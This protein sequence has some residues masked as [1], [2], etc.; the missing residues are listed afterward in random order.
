MSNEINNN[1]EAV[2]IIGMAARL[3]GARN[4]AEYWDNLKKGV[5]SITFWTD[6]ELLAAGLDPEKIAN[7]NYV[8]AKGNIPEPFHFDAGFFGFNPREA[9]VLDPQHRVF[10]EC[11]WHAFEDAGY[12]PSR[13]EQRVGV[14]AG[15]GTTQYLFQL[16]DNPEV[17]KFASALSIVT[18]N[19]KDYISTRVSYKLNLTGPSV[20]VQSACSSS[21][22]AVSMGAQSILNYQCD[23][24]IAG[25]VSMRIPEVAG[26]WYQEGS[27]VSPD[28]HCRTFDRNSK[29]T[30]FSAGCAV[31]L[32]KRL[33]DAIRD[34]DHIYAV[35]KGS[36]V[37]NDG[38]LKIGYTAPSVDGQMEVSAEA[39]AMS[40]IHPETIH[41]FEAHGTATELGDPIEVNA[42]T[43]V[44]R[45][46]TDKQQYCAIASVK[47]NIGHTDIAAGTAGLIKTALTLEH[48]L[49][50][51]N[52]HYEAPNP[53]IDFDNSPFFVNTEL[54]SYPKADHPRR[55]GVNSFG[56]GGTNA[57]AI[58]EQAPER[59]ATDA[60]RPHQLLVLSTRSET[61]LE[62]ATT[63][64]VEHLKNHEEQ[65]L[66]DV[67]FTL[68]NGR[69]DLPFRRAVVVTSREEAIETLESR[70]AATVVTKP[71]APENAPVCF[72]F[73]GQGSQYANMGRDLYESEPLF[74][75]IVDDCC[76]TLQPEL[77]LDLRTII[78]NEDDRL[79]Q[80]QYTQPSLFVI[81]YALAKLWE[82]WGIKP[83]SMVGH[84]VG[85]YVAATLAGVLSLEDAL[86]LI[87]LRGRLMQSLPAGSML[88]VLKSEEET[89]VILSEAK[90]PLRTEAGDPSSSSR[91]RM[92]DVIDV[93][94]IN[95][96]SVTVVSGPTDAITAL[97]QSLQKKG[98]GCRLL[99]TSHAFHSSMMDPIL[100]AFEKAV[101]QV[102][103]NAPALPYFSN[104][105]GTW[106][107]AED[108]T[109]PEYWSRHLRG[110][111]RF[112]DAILE[113]LKNEDRVFLEVG[114]NRALQSSVKQH[115][116]TLD[117]AVIC[118]MRHPDDAQ[119]DAAFAL[120]ALG[121]LWSAG[122]KIDWK[123]YYGEERRARVALPGYP[124]ERER[125]YIDAAPR[126]AE[127]K[128]K[129]TIKTQDIAEWFYVPS[130]KKTPNAAL[131]R[132][133]KE[134][135][136]SWLIFTDSLGLGDTVAAKLEANGE[137]VKRVAREGFD[138]TSRAAYDALLKE[139]KPTKIIHLWNFTKNDDTRDRL[140][141]TLGDESFYGLLALWQSLAQLNILD[142]L[143]V[144]VFS[145]GV[146]DVN[147]EIVTS[148]EKALLIG[149]CR[150]FP[151]EYETVE[152]R[153]IDIDEY[154]NVDT[155]INEMLASSPYETAI[156][157]RNNVRWTE[158]SEHVRVG[159][160]EKALP[161][162]K[163]NGTYLVT[164]AFGGIGY[165]VA[166][167]LAEKYKA[168][169]VM[170]GR[171]AVP[172]RAEWDAYVEANGED[173]STTERIRKVQFLEELGA[174]IYAASADVANLAQMQKIAD[175]ARERFGRVDGVFHVAGNAG[176]GV[177]PLKT[178]EAAEAV[179]SPKVRGTLVL[180]RLFETDF[181][182]LFSSLTG[183][184]GSAGQIDYTAAN[185]FMDAF[186]KFAR[187]NGRNVVA[188][189]WDAWQEVGMAV[190]DRSS[191]QKN[192]LP[193]GEKYPHPLIDREILHNDERTY[194]ARLGS[195]SHWTVGE[196]LVGGV[197]TLVGTGYLEI[198]RAASTERAAGRQIEI[199]DA[200]F[201]APFMVPAGEKKT[202]QLT[203][204]ANNDGEDFSF[205][206]TSGAYGEA[207]IAQDHMLGKIRYAAPETQKQHD[208]YHDIEAIFARCPRIDDKSFGSDT[209]DLV[210]GVVEVKARW[211]N[212]S[213]V[214]V[215]EGEA[216]AELKLRDEYIG[217]L[218]S[219][220]LHP[221]LLDV[222][223][224]YAM[225]YIA[226][227]GK[228]FL[229]FF[230]K[231]FAIKGRMTQRVFA[232]AR[233]TPSN[234]PREMLP[235]DITIMD[236]H[237][238]EL[239][240]IEQYTLKRIPEE[241]MNRA[242]ESAPKT[243][244]KAKRKL[245]IGLRNAEGT[246]VIERILATP[247]GPQVV[248][249]TRDFDALLESVKP[250][251]GGTA[252]AALNSGSSKTKS[253]HARPNLKTEYV[254]PRNEV[255]ESVA[256]IWAQVIGIEKVGVND[257]FVE[258]GGHSLLAI[259][260][261]SRVR[262]TFQ[263]ELPLDS[264]YKAPSVAGMAEAIIVKLTESTDEEAL[265]AMLAELEEEA[266]V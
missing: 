22:V 124:F 213:R 263:V 251:K 149:A 112:S 106:I 93:A 48:D 228:A 42:L 8:K 176:G 103:L 264:L 171:S 123:A 111:V 181:M 190:E 17:H 91:L 113:L 183:Q 7:P 10:L 185:R 59:E 100:P 231:R 226:E 240:V 172:P 115:P 158:S 45:T 78:F 116:D 156:A 246:E 131:L 256:E 197:P 25:G 105:T 65:D 208:N 224:A 31:V 12:D 64:L 118:S 201:M 33:S 54:R 174:N 215:G 261:M 89:R 44:F 2:A 229:P 134:I 125:Y 24:A 138:V 108:A 166:E 248:V 58:L 119:S 249:V 114:P 144:G 61:S 126:V 135:K 194:L 40:G 34:R 107:T 221:A 209:A 141:A 20:N 182:L 13:T 227:P 143:R 56:V 128:P 49:I 81:E 258:L 178:R 179:L 241:F 82:S 153:A 30:I 84:S 192:D 210:S 242:A 265:A 167:H 90:D 239:I 173:D 146:H 217:D 101:A 60:A 169:I 47:T 97:Q 85:E 5:E 200:Y 222:A 41:Y 15:T 180:D 214:R 14:W 186:A 211:K 23:M 152:C 109:S 252:A 165:V 162:L 207:Q 243:E 196:H 51:K 121:R 130:W 57:Q 77:G 21:L 6:E 137:T 218:D 104:V 71:W 255:E 37:N 52:L 189:D 234:E 142:P 129:Q 55:A 150:V 117:R 157:Y 236:E 132:D 230:Y 254:A 79:G 154:I 148:P 223:T 161:V 9:E 212:A 205:K 98:V 168:N 140:D 63:N 96:P 177:I 151:Q 164:G 238:R 27:I 253:T 95:G 136:D 225:A 202:L 38:Q 220:Y 260:L 175:T 39:I 72:L 147:G 262:D 203:L 170:I 110:A 86:R 122:V 120:N 160:N 29:G 68:Q 257:G 145:N 198:A 188:I 75:S 127:E 232:H 88:A 235:L 46:Y 87:A 195:K 76:A 43:K 102:Q 259:Q 4:V 36:A 206:S 28:G 199:R 80:T 184:V 219:F 73:S 245:A 70:D 233:F 53:E 32:L 66:A 191:A 187:A 62:T 250:K 247:F 74:R 83:E 3:P 92:T 94:A 18:G 16:N 26:Y 133:T 11:A 204:K 69:K 19:D 139:F 266:A 193:A 155:I 159:K 50:P 67:A 1:E 237:G 163:E 216:I 99:H 244:T 35:I